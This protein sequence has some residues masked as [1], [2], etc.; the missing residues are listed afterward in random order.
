VSRPADTFR[1]LVDRLR[2]PEPVVTIELRPPR[3]GLSYADSMDV[4]IDMYHSL[5]RLAREDLHVFLTDNAVGA[6][7]E[8]S[9]SHLAANLADDVHPGRIVPFLT[10]K[11]ALEY[12]LMFARRTASHGFQALT[13]LG[14]DDTVGPPRCVPHSQ[15]LRH[16]IRKE[17]PGLALGGWANPHRDAAEQAGY[18]ATD[19]FEADFYLTQVV[20]HH[21]AAGVEAL[22]EES[23]RRG[24][25]AP[26]VFGVFYYR[27]ANP[28]TLETLGEFFPVPAEELT[29]EFESGA[30]PDEICAR[31]IVA[32]RRAGAK[33]IY[34]SN[35]G[36]RR[37]EERYRRI[38]NAVREMEAAG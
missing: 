2:D 31:S 12:C 35:L 10:C 27:S 37:V 9:L 22:L 34:L 15:D 33:N 23:G 29:R 20:S 32:L 14:G 17:A 36:F 26:G 1:P 5:Q 19:D 4:W 28:K 21:S 3:S 30:G 11:H 13:V 24:L 8:E 16:L 6:S 7:E 38:M 25:D 18:I